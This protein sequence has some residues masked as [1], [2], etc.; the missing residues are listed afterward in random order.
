[1]LPLEKAEYSPPKQFA[2]GGLEEPSAA[3]QPWLEQGIA[4]DSWLKV[5]E[6]ATKAY[7]LRPD[8]ACGATATHF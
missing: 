7:Q 3:G 6:R 2:R 4:R 5:K 1:M 8:V